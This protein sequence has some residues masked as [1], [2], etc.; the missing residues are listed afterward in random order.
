MPLG[1]LHLTWRKLRRACISGLTLK[2]ANVDLQMV[3]HGKDISVN[4]LRQQ[5]QI[6]VIV[7]P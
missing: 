5:G 2:D 3:R 7:L 1:T 6:E 4:V